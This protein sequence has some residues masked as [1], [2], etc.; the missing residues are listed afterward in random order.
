M[1]HPLDLCIGQRVS[2]AHEDGGEPR[3]RQDG[4]KIDP[5]H[6]EARFGQDTGGTSMLEIN[7]DKQLQGRG[8]QQGLRQHEE[9]RWTTDSAVKIATEHRAN[10]H[11]SENY[12]Q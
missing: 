7:A 1:L 5:V 3:E 10:P 11:P 8:N 9:K 2:E 4:S 6:R 12:G